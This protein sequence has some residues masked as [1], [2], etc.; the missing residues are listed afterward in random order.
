M[1]NTILSVSN[2]VTT[3][4]NTILRE[5]AI[6]TIDGI[7][8]VPYGKGVRK[9][10]LMITVTKK[11][12]YTVNMTF[13]TDTMKYIKCTPLG[14]YTKHQILMMDCDIYQ[15][16]NKHITSVISVAIAEPVEVVRITEVKE[17]ATYI[18]GNRSF[19][20]YSNAVAYCEGNDWDALEMVVQR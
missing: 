15:L 6:Y 9:D 5:D 17:E 20:D 7:Y 12:D 19:E 8:T 18:V 10:Q 4:I 11:G 16:F 13:N 3:N 2:E 1:K 14:K